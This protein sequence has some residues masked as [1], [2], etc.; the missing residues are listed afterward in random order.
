M[1]QGENV[2][3]RRLNHDDIPILWEFIYGEK[4]PEWK[5]WD[6]PY[7]PVGFMTRRDFEKEKKREAKDLYSN[8][9]Y[10]EAN[11][12]LIGMVTY[13]WEHQPSNWLEVGIVIYEPS[14]WHKGA[15][16]E[17]LKLWI[18]HLFEKYKLIRIGLSTW[19][20]NTRIIRVAEKTGMREEGRIRKCRF[21]NGVYYDAIKMGMLREEWLSFSFKNV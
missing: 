6:A 5:K 16:T 3:L 9:M 13:Y 18:R 15:G 12:R 19:S 2:L 11:G 7:F 21:Y 20:G 1:I 8:K 10:I 4:D 14:N 17:A